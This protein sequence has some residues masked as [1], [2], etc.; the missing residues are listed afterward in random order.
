MK[1]IIFLFFSLI[2]SAHYV[3]A[4]S[5]ERQSQSA[6]DVQIATQPKLVVG[7]VVDQMRYD[8]LTRFWDRYGDDGF[9]RLIAEGFLCKNAHYNYVPTYTAPGHSSVYTGTSPRFHGIISNTWYQKSNK[10]YVY[11]VADSTEHGVG[12]D[13][14]VG[15]SSPHR[16]L[17]TT[18]P[19]QNRLATQF[20]GKTISVALKDRAAILPAGHTA[21]AAYWFAGHDEG[22]FISS[23]YYMKNLPQWVK[24]FNASGKAESYMKTWSTLYPIDTYTESGPD[25]NDYEGGF[26][27]KETATFPYELAKLSKENG[28]Y[29]ILKGVPYGDDLTVDFAIAAI[30]GEELGQDAITDFLTVSFSATDYVGHNFGVNSKE[31]EDTY[32]RL[33][34]TI[35]RL[36]KALDKK[37]GRG[38]YTLF[39]TS[40]HAG[41]HVAA[42]LSDKKIPAG[43]FD[44]D[45]L[46]DK[47]DSYLDEKYGSTNLIASV[48]NHQIFFNYAEVDEHKISRRELTRQIRYFLLTYPDIAQVY[49]REALSDNAYGSSSPI[50]K[51]VKN[52]FNPRRSGDVVFVLQPGRVPDYAD[53]GSTHGS[54]YNYDTHVPIIFYGKGINHGQTIRHVRIIDLAPTISALLGINAPNAATGTP[55]PEVIK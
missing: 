26:D 9:K 48:S 14:K 7:I 18:L 3:T 25:L 12:T 2:I 10:D 43:L 32:L 4:Q 28:G 24:D 52:G 50:G 45:V 21:N 33:D 37:V 15:E 19:D 8:Y 6:Q 29:S 11:C 53:T 5:T 22:E 54:T 13:Q 35:A 34:K 23:T 40:D 31:V 47:L 49:T 16:L 41:A 1:N 36:L 38:N 44:E 17:V 42:Y 55:I 27:G 51:R 46:E 30:D 20:R 39:L